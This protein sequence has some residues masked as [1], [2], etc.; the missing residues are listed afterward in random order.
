M[1]TC[2]K[3]FVKIPV[4]PFKGIGEVMDKRLDS[5]CPNINK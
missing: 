3:D 1:E 5:T 2:N 4:I